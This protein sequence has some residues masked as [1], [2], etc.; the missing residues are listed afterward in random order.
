MRNFNSTRSLL[1]S[2][3][4][5]CIRLLVLVPV[6]NYLWYRR[7][8]RHELPSALCSVRC[9]CW[10]PTAAVLIREVCGVYSLLHTGIDTVIVVLYWQSASTPTAVL[11][12]SVPFPEPSLGPTANGSIISLYLVHFIFLCIYLLSCL[13]TSTSIRLLRLHSQ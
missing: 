5:L 11:E 13:Y 6:Q 7:Q 12:R 3:G 8:L 1:D 2:T 10:N 9:S 4:D